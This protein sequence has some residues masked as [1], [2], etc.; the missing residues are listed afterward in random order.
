MLLIING[1]A[2][3]GKS[4]TVFAISKLINR[5][6]KRCAPTTKAAFLIKRETLHSQFNINTKN[7]KENYHRIDGQKLKNLQDKFS[8]IMHIIIDEY[9]MLSQ[10]M[11]GIIDKRLR[12]ATGIENEFFGGI[13]VILIG[14]PGQ[15]LLVGGAP[16]YQFPQTSILAT[17][18]FNCY[19]E[20]KHAVC[21]EISVRQQNLKN[22]ENQEKFIKL[23]MRIRDGINDQDTINDWQFLLKRQTSIS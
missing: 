9:S 17:H 11:L 1:T 2:G 4:F 6:L 23:L 15:L 19:L 20:F 13:S 10:V 12:Q 21:L 14:D 18:G 22:D 7:D 3:T 16:L 8:A 5:K